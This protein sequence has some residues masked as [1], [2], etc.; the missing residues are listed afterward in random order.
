[1]TKFKLPINTQIIPF[2]INLRKE[3]WLFVSI[4]EP[5]SKSN[6]YFLDILGDLVNF[7]SHDY[8][9]KVILGDFNLEPFN[10]SIASFMNKQHLFN[11]IKG[12]TRFKGEGSCNGLILTNEK[13][14]F[15]N[16][17]SFEIGL[18]LSCIML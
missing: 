7:C 9:N 3:K 6:Q 16:T 11:F 13:Y 12:N 4:Y 17:C 2:E 10:P 8:G 5:P 1:M 15:K 14:S 18:T